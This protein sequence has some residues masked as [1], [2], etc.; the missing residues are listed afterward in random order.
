MLQ[1]VA[2]RQS[3]YQESVPLTPGRYR[4]N[5][6]A[7]DII[8]GNMNNYELA[9]DVPHYDEEK[10]AQQPDSCRHH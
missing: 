4:L 3:I 1:K 5:I 7:K 2:A 9:L 10:L 8:A 6:V